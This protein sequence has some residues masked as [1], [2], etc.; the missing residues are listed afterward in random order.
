MKRIYFEFFHVSK[1]GKV[2]EKVMLTRIAVSISIIIACLVAMSFA[3]YAY[4][5]YGLYSNNNTITA[6][7]YELSVKA[8]ENQINGVTNITETTEFTISPTDE[9]NAS[10][11]Y[12]KIDIITTDN[13]KPYTFYT[14]PIWREADVENNKLSERIVKIEI[15]E[16][17]ALKVEVA[18]TAEW[19]TYSGEALN[20]DIITADLIGLAATTPPSPEEPPQLQESIGQQQAVTFTE[21][22]DKETASVSSIS[23]EN[24]NDEAETKDVESS[25]TTDTLEITE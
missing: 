18:F 9:T 15:P 24:K 13:E 2:S 12:C 14:A 5:S 25:E 19:G 11:G 4:F 7:N 16:G 10:V 6:A 8:G 22:S 1:H 23:T 20:N 21:Q 3:A 17:N